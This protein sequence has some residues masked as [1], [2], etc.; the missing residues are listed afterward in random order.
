MVKNR[1][2]KAKTQNT[3]KQSSPSGLLELSEDE[4]W[5]I[6]N[7]TGILKKYPRSSENN[8]EAEAV[9]SPGLADEV[10]NATLFIIPMSFMLLL[11]EILVHWQYGQR[12]TFRTL[13][14]RMLPGVPIISIFVFYTNRYKRRREMQFCFFLVT[15]I[16]GPRLIWL[17]NMANWRTVMKQ[18]PPAATLWIYAVLQMELAPSVISLV[19]IA[20][21]TWLSKMRILF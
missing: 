4:Q 6:L 2:G 5:R 9:D 14:D 19:L 13:M 16:L 21:W 11:F 8:A 20:L 12:P 7:E 10:F 18:C 1:K 17:I 15:L 3:S